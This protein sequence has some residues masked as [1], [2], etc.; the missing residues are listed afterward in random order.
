[1]K[2]EHLNRLIRMKQVSLCLH[3]RKNTLFFSNQKNKG[4]EQEEQWHK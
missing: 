3:T 2:G 1:M 4:V